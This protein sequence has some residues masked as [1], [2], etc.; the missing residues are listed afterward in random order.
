MAGSKM[1]RLTLELYWQYTAHSMEWSLEIDELSSWKL[2]EEM[3]CMQLPIFSFWEK[4]HVKHEALNR[5]HKEHSRSSDLYP[6]CSKA[7]AIDSP[8]MC[9]V[10]PEQQLCVG[11]YNI[12]SALFNRS[13]ETPG[14]TILSP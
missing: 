7:A 9:H 8:C 13:S 5:I 10:F 6:A 4:S 11:V 2:D 14:Y 3:L 12:L 1:W